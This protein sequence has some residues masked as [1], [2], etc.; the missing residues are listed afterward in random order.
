MA[1][2]EL[3]NELFAIYRVELNLIL[4]SLNKKIVVKI[5]ANTNS[6]TLPNICVHIR[7]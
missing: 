7:R 3:S 2:F 1:K 6:F 5:E 4:N